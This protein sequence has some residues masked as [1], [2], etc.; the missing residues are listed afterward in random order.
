MRSAPSCRCCSPTTPYIST[1]FVSG[2]CSACCSIVRHLHFLQQTSERTGQHY[3]PALTRAYA[4]PS[5]EAFVIYNF[6][7]LCLSYVGGPGAVEVK[8]NG[9]L[10][11]PSCWYCTCCLP[12]QLVDGL[13]VRRCK[14]GA[15][16]FVLLMPIL[17]ILSTLLYATHHYHPGNWGAS[18]GCARPLH[19]SQVQH[20]LEQEFL[21]QHDGRGVGKLWPV[22]AGICTS[23]LCT[24]SPTAW[25]CLRCS[26][27]IWARM[28]CWRPSTRC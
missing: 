18:D 4:P 20:R 17:G 28:R 24:T 10:L 23:P 16:Q 8:M 9:Y 21:L 5:Y 22:P 1:P 3:S 27:S 14:Q 26:C 25:H 6:L 11:M 19:W 7:A 2:A 15:L 12:P 13:F